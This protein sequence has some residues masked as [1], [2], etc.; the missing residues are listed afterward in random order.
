M[1]LAALIGLLASCT[2]PTAGVD[3]PVSALRAEAASELAPPGAVVLRTVQAEP[4]NNITG[5]EAAFYG[6]L[7]GL[8]SAAADIHAFY[9]RELTKLGWR[10]TRRP[11][12]GTT[13]TDGWRWCKP[14]LLF[15]LGILDPRG[16]NRIPLTSAAQYKTV[17]DARLSGTDEAC[18]RT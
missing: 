2:A 15:R 8:S 1:I 13:E 17:I 11:I 3:L 9:D 14:M 4:F 10:V 5:H 12:L 16:Y 6:H 7:F 18:P